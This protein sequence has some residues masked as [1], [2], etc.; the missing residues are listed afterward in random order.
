ME[1]IDVESFER[2]HAVFD[3]KMSLCDGAKCPASCC[4]PKPGES[5]GVRDSYNTILL[6]G[7][8]D[9]LK[10]ITSSGVMKRVSGQLIPGGRE[11]G[12]YAISGCLVPV[13]GIR[14][15]LF[16]KKMCVFGGN[17]P[18]MCTMHPFF[19]GGFEPI[20]SLQCHRWFELSQDPVLVEKVMAFRREL[21]FVVDREWMR[22]LRATQEL[23][24]LI[25][26]GVRMVG[27]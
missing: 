2:A 20:M 15:V 11:V 23:H 19:L 6:S 14:G 7:E 25:G 17:R 3:G 4:L 5:I 24:G 16:G 22:R 10:T 21:G 8:L 13:P 9:Y 1:K 12:E 26:R 27:F 18:A